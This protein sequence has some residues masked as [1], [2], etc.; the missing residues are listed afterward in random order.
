MLSNVLA[1]P[2]VEPVVVLVEGNVLFNDTFNTFYL[3]LYSI[4]HMAKNHSDND[5]GNQLPLLHGLFLLISSKGPFY[6]HCPAQDITYSFCY[7]SCG[8]MA[9]M[10]NSSD[11]CHIFHIGKC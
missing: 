6:M 4:G 2:M 8:A 5:R 1:R 9:G 11:A 10:R 7:T 3:W